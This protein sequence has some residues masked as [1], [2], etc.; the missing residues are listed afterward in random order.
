MFR[1]DE[2]EQRLNT[3]PDEEEMM[4]A[5]EKDIYEDFLSAIRVIDTNEDIG[6]LDNIGS[7]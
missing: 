5:S 6:L 1:L 7:K 3:L 4:F 2:L